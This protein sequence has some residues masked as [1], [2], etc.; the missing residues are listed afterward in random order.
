MQ[1]NSTTHATFQSKLPVTSAPQK[2]WLKRKP[3]MPFIAPTMI[4]MLLLFVLPIVFVAVISLTN[5]KLG[6]P[7]DQIRFLGLGNYLRLFNGTESGFYHS[8]SISLIFTVAGTLLQLVIG[9]ACAMIL[10]CEFKGKAIA[11]AC[12]IVPIAMTPS[13]A[14]QIWKLMLNQEFGVINYFLRNILGLT[15]SWLDADHAFL[16]VLIATVWQ[17]TPFVTLML[18]AGL[19]SLPESPYESARLEGA[20]KLQMFVY[21]TL[22]MMKRLLILCSLLRIIDMLKTF[23]IPY[24]L[25][26]GGPDTATQFLSLIIYDTGFGESN[27]VGR[28]SAMAVVLIVIV[29]LLSLFLFRTMTKS[30]ED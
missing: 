20:S 28:A 27:F 7:L 9:M 19:R 16:S 30:R 29:S 17:Y 4:V 6:V 15:V 1:T 2:P 23:D 24:V 25:T 18:Y 22:P 5:Y 21:I 11:V 3:H 12:L 13:I 10:N 14:S 26:Q 8:V